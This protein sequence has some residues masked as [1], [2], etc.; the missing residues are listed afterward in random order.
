MSTHL[1]LIPF[2]IALCITTAAIA[3][4]TLKIVPAGDSITEGCCGNSSTVDS[5]R[6]EFAELLSATN[7]GFEMRGS[8]LETN[9][10]SSY[11]SPHEGYSG[12]WAFHFIN[13]HPSGPKAIEDIVADELPDVIVMHLGLSLIHI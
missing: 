8:Q 10:G 13:G 2:V 1:K 5:Y 7:C 6:R 11:Q 3:Q 12:W 4:P 9:N